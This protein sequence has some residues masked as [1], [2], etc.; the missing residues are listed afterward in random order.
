MDVKAKSPTAFAKR[1]RNI[2]REPK[3][4]VYTSFGRGLVQGDELPAPRRVFVPVGEML[5]V[6]R[7][8]KWHAKWPGEL[9]KKILEM[10]DVKV[11]QHANYEDG[12]MCPDFALKWHT[13]TVVFSDDGTLSIPPS[14]MR[15]GNFHCNVKEIVIPSWWA[16]DEHHRDIALLN[17]V[18]RHF[19]IAVTEFTT[20]DARDNTLKTVHIITN[21]MTDAINHYGNKGLDY[22]RYIRD[23]SINI[24]RKSLLVDSY[25]VGEVPDVLLILAELYNIKF[26]RHKTKGG[27]DIWI[28]DNH[29]S[30]TTP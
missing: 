1:R 18:C 8:A 2:R 14:E 23:Q 16:P 7:N 29:Q 17:S 27:E 11:V 12:I 26:L 19:N 6:P 13:H 9:A 4:A 30:P 20:L 24:E 5:S 3:D 15:A 28:L 21:K 22:E 10:F 25:Y